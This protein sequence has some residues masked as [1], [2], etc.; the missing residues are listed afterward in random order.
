LQRAA[1]QCKIMGVNN[2]SVDTQELSFASYLN[3]LTRDCFYQLRQLRTVARS[4][5]TGAAATLVHS[6]VTNRLD[7]CLCLY[8]ALCGT[9]YWPNTK[10][11]PRNRLHVGGSA[12]APCPIASSCPT[13]HRVGLYRVASLVWRCQLGIAPIHLIDLCRSV[14]GIASGRSLSSARRGSSQSRLLVPPSCKF[15]LF[16]L[17][18]RRCGMAS[19]LS[20]ASCLGRFPTHSIVVFKL[21]FLTVLESGAP[22]SSSGIEEAL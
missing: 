5:S 20:C 21:F 11:R 17:I 18:A 16:A 1:Y 9:P 15:A 7:C 10:V 6:F 3:R 19:L 4:L 13:A 8:S 12:L 14:S 22:L 2:C